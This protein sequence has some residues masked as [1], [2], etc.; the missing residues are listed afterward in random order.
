MY[1]KK[2][3]LSLFLSAALFMGSFFGNGTYHTVH[4]KQNHLHVQELD[5]KF[6]QN[7]LM[8][9]SKGVS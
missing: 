4:A 5:G 6:T 9:E 2:K 3:Y 7:N 8:S 1:Q